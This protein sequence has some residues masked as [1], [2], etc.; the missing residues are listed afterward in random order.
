M[1]DG[2]E[3]SPGSTGSTI[4]TAVSISMHEK[5]LPAVEIKSIVPHWL[6]VLK[7]SPRL[8]FFNSG[9]LP[10]LGNG[11]HISFADDAFALE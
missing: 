3:A 5:N 2:A 9:A 6:F 4:D 7:K 1:S 8:W 10:E 11:W